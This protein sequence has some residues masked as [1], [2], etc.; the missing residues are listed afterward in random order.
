MSAG[1]AHGTGKRCPVC[2]QPYAYR[3]R[4][5]ELRRLRIAG[6][7][8]ERLGVVYVHELDPHEAPPYTDGWWRR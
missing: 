2:G 7:R 3:Y 5:G 1:T 6:Y 8:H 4:A